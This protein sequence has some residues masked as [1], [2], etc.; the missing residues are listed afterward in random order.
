MTIRATLLAATIGTA[1]LLAQP[2]T[3]GGPVIVEDTTETV[4]PSRDRNL[5]PLIIIGALIVG[6]FLASGGN[7]F[8]EEPTPEP[9]PPTGG[10]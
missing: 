1:L 4:T 2:V 9:T 10:C 5:V 3:A 8:A 6:G 7:C